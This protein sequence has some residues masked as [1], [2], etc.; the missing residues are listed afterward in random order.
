[1]AEAPASVWV[2]TL[3]FF[4]FERRVGPKRPFRSSQVRALSP[5][6][7]RSVALQRTLTFPMIRNSSETYV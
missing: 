5:R 1:M 3:S 2:W 7:R 6:V 4:L